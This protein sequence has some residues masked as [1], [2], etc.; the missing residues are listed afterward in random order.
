MNRSRTCKQIAL[1]SLITIA[2]TTVQ[3][4]VVGACVPDDGP[5]SALYS[6][7]STPAQADP[8]TAAA[9]ATPTA[10]PPNDVEPSLTVTYVSCLASVVAL[11]W[12]LLRL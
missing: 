11:V 9:A 8:S 7:F 5:G 2:A 10:R 3:S 6:P 1:A 4:E 12:L